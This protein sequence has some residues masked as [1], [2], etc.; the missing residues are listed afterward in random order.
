[1]NIDDQDAVETSA[2]VNV[3][4]K[5]GI[6]SSAANDV[7]ALQGKTER[8]VNHNKPWRVVIKRKVADGGSNN[9]YISGDNINN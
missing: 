1:M 2:A 7:T 4:I 6:N 5:V 8:K 9:K 3:S